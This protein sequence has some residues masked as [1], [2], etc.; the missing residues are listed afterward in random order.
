MAND[1]DLTH[2][3]DAIE[4]GKCLA[5]LGAGTSMAYKIGK[6]KVSGL[7]SGDDLAK[8]LT[9][10]CGSLNGR[11]SD[12]ARV[13]EYFVYCKNGDRTQLES[14]LQKTIYHIREARP[15]HTVLAQLR[16]LKIVITSNYDNLLE[17]ELGKYGRI[18][19]RDVYDQQDPKTAHF[20]GSVFLDEGEVVLH[21]M[22]GSIDVPRSMIIT[23]SDYIR[24]LANL[25]DQDLGMPDY[26]RVTMIPQHILLFLGYS[27]EDWNFRV[28]WEGVL[29]RY[30]NT[31][32]SRKSYAIVKSSN[33]F[34]KSF[35]LQR[36]IEIIDND[37]ID[38][39]KELAKHFNLEIPQL[40]IK[41]KLKG[42]NS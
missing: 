23:Q 3:F 1:Q 38:F 15:I 5:F 29:A 28:I 25:T 19:S 24:Y 36:N 8:L 20:K 14:I 41:M 35:W 18:M 17:T 42:S 33:K 6:K 34:Q 21:K 37:L 4:S 13:A 30:K 16:Q 31:G 10:K 7:P 9:K 32:V 39:A 12:L 22:H 11:V 40:K 27:L 2:I 26:F